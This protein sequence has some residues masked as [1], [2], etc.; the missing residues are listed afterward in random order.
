MA[1]N[2]EETERNCTHFLILAKRFHFGIPC[3]GLNR[4]AYINGFS[5]FQIR[6]VVIQELRA[7]EL[8]ICGTG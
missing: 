5:A 8:G 1:F 7:Y 4:S 6:K 3:S 2:T